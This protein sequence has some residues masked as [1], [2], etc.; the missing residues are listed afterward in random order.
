MAPAADVAFKVDGFPPAKNEALSMLGAGHEHGSRVRKLL[1]AAKQALPV[2]FE[3][4]S[5]HVG[6]DVTVSAPEGRDPWDATNYLGGIGDVLEDKRH[7]GSL[8]H[9]G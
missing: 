3:P 4:F 5:T 1:E 6:L 8:P 9:L 2:G 7:R